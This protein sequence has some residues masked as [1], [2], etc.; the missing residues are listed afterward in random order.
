MRSTRPKHGVPQH[1]TAPQQLA[2]SLQGY[3]NT[4]HGQGRKQALAPMLSAADVSTPACTDAQP[5]HRWLKPAR[6]L[7][8]WLL[9]AELV[10][11]NKM[12]VEC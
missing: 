6:H 3:E 4:R 10:L 2:V 8:H 9:A 11:R 12:L 7:Q 5:P 1:T